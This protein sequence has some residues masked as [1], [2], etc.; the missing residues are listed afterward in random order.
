MFNRYLRFFS[1]ALT[2]LILVAG[3]A[4]ARQTPLDSIVAVVNDE[5]ILASELDAAVQNAEQQIRQQQA[6]LP[7]SAVL[8][9]QV[10]EQMINQRLQVQAARDAGISVDDRTLNQTV[11]NI[12]RE[13]NVSLDEFR[14]IL[15]RDGYDYAEFR[16]ELRREILVTRLRQQ[17][18]DSRVQVTEREIER[19]LSR[20]E[21]ADED[22]EYHLAHILVGLPNDPSPDQ[23]EEAQAQAERIRAELDEG[24]SFQDAAVAHSDAPDAL[25]GGDLGWRSPAQ[26]PSVFEEVVGELEPGEYS[27][28]LRSANG[29]HIVQLIDQRVGDAEQVTEYRIRQILLRD[30][31]NAQTRLDQLRNRIQRGEDFAAL[32]R[33][34]SDDSDSAPDGGDL[35]WVTEA[36]VPPAVADV[37]LGL[38]EGQV[39]A[40]FE[41][42]VGWHLVKV[43]ETR[44]QDADDEQRRLQAREQ[45]RRRKIE[46]EH[47]AWVRQLR[48]EAYVDQ[49][50]DDA[51]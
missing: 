33:S 10:L 49:R 38:N 23:V 44:T 18:V 36:D 19:F 40:P 22:R 15:E 11:R 31:T 12:A 32:A 24:R 5:V 3:A 41:S 4:E 16:E 35:G 2:A 27:E 30:A 17:R 34:H 1:C 39:S 48:D 29:F 51:G 42:R 37:M 47:Q 50:L 45:L 6:Q 13:N 9:R 20:R 43:E 7:P 46:E 14:R 28:P 26:V 25:E 8:E 21:Q